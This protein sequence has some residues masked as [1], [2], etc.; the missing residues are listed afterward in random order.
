MNTD[1]KFYEFLEDLSTGIV[2]HDSDTTVV[3]ANQSALDFLGLTMDEIQGKQAIDPYWHFLREDGKNMEVEELPVQRVLSTGKPL[4]HLVV[5]VTRPD[6][7]YPAWALCS[8]RSRMDKETNR[9]QIIVIFEDITERIETE[10]KLIE[11]QEQLKRTNVLAKI[12]LWRWIIAKD[13]VIWSDEL[14]GIAGRDPELPPPSYS[15]TDK[16][17]T[18]KS[19]EHLQLAVGKALADGT[20]YEIDMDFVLPDK[21][22]RNTVT[23]GGVKRDRKGKIIELYGIVQDIT[24]R[25]QIQKEKENTLELLEQ[26]GRMGKIG[27]WELD[28][29]TNNL[30]WSEETYRIHELENSTKVQLETAINYLLHRRSRWQS[31]LEFLGI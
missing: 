9:Q 17:C 31:T 21:S 4:K 8:A 2:V 24:D 5:G 14:Y 6:L 29:I 27:G 12:G 11:T 28:L 1:R 20:S 23:F 13:T 10:K 22:I 26:I 30:W 18:P 25:K 16:I 3:Y 15:Q 7:D 19:W